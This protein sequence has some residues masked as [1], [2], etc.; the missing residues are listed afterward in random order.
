[1]YLEAA[2]QGDSEGQYLYGSY[3]LVSNLTENIMKKKEVWN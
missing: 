3:L 1:M 2:D